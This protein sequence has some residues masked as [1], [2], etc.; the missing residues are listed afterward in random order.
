MR[1]AVR[2]CICAII[3]FE[4]RFMILFL[5]S[6]TIFELTA[7]YHDEIIHRAEIFH[8]DFMG[9]LVVELPFGSNLSS[10]NT[11]RYFTWVEIAFDGLYGLPPLPGGFQTLSFAPSFSC[12]GHG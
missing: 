3:L 5:P 2:P 7:V 10:S 12:S 6:E 11:S 1:N 8:A 4:L 9:L